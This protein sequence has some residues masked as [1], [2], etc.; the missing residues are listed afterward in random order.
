MQFLARSKEAFY[1]LCAVVTVMLGVGLRPAYAGSYHLIRVPNSGVTAANGINKYNQIVGFYI[2]QQNGIRGYLLS[3]GKYTTISYGS[4]LVEVDG[5]NDYGV[6]VGFY[7]AS[8]QG[9]LHGFILEKGKFKTIDY[10]GANITIPEAINNKGEVVGN[11]SN[12]SGTQHLFKYMNGRFTGFNI[13]GASRT[14]GVGGV[15]DNGDM[16]GFYG[17]NGGNYGFILRSDGK[18]L[19]IKDPHDPGNTGLT[20]MNNKFQAVGS[21][22]EDTT[23]TSHGFAWSGGKFIE[24]I[25]YPGATSTIPQ[26]INDKGIVVGCWFVNSAEKGFYYVP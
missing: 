5:I 10:P 14:E 21:W 4:N 7:A 12:E 3:D 16:S 17:N 11:W 2:D 6:M 25:N 8:T 18:L 9:P 1:V 26:A 15:D 13:A 19:T 22:F 24:S 23:E 20:G